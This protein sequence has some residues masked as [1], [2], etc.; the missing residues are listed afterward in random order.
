MKLHYV[1]LDF[2]VQRHVCDMHA[3]ESDDYSQVLQ[4]LYA[5]LLA[6]TLMPCV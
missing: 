3:N 2:V 4:A 1:T 5:L 6:L